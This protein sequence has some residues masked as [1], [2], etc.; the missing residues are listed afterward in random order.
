MPDWDLD[1]DDAAT[2]D[3]DPENDCV[4]FPT[5]Q[6]DQERY[7]LFDEDCERE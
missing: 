1:Q 4:P 3:R 5:L 6:L 7:R 2:H